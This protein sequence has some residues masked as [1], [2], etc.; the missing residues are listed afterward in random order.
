MDTIVAVPNFKRRGKDGQMLPVEREALYN[1]VKTYRPS[2][3][4]EV[5]TYRGYGST[6]YI[7]SALAINGNG[8]VLHSY[9]IDEKNVAYVAKLYS[10][11]KLASL[12]KSLWLHSGDVLALQHTI[13]QKLDF[14]FLDGANEADETAKQ[15]TC[16]LSRIVRGTIVALHDWNLEKQR[17]T[18]MYFSNNE[19]RW[20]RLIEINN[21]PTGFAAF[22]RR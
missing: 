13:P 20:S 7:T 17:T 3:C 9:E 10:S 6:Y 8:G 11:G 1:L 15:L 21:T 14:I 22:K 2:Q 12:G 4:I 16:F 19:Q 18:R 5:G